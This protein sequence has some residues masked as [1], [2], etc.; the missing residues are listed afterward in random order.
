GVSPQDSA[1]HRRFADKH[2]LEFILLA[3][4]KKQA[5]KAYDVD[6][7]LGF[8]VRRAS[9]LIAADG[10]ILDSIQ[11]DFMIDRHDEFFRR[12]AA[13]MKPTQD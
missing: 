4:E 3:D 5:V 6:G 10:T 7:P 12:A 9:F 11:A 1:S 8:G 2:Q 13:Q